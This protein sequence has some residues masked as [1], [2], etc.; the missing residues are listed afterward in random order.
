MG[1]DDRVIVYFLARVRDF[2]SPKC[3][4]KQVF[5]LLE[6]GAVEVS[7]VLGSCVFSLGD[8]CVMFQDYHTV[9]KCWAPILQCCKH[10]TSEEQR[11]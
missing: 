1:S 3:P 4:D 7:V 8:S 5:G 10:S 6:C 11:P 2:L 9:Q